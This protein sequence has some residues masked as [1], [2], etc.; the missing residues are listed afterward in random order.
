MVEGQTGLSHQNVHQSSWHKQHKMGVTCL[1]QIWPNWSQLGSLLC[2]IYLCH[3]SGEL[4]LFV[5]NPS[6]LQ[7]YLGCSQLFVSDHDKLGLPSFY[8]V[9]WMFPIKDIGLFSVH[10]ISYFMAYQSY[11][12]H[13]D[14]LMQERR[15]SI[16]NALKLR[17]SRTNPSIMMQENLTGYQEIMAWW[18]R[19]NKIFPK[20]SCIFSWETI[21]STQLTL[22]KRHTCDVNCFLLIVQTT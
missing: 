12:L 3:I 5:W 10:L 17:L 1:G 14:G 4:A 18:Q 2:N 6:I 11:R 16:V 19:G 15:N 13:I 9:F 21:C 22:G 20:R 7:V 8:L